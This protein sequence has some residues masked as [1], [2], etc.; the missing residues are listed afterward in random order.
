MATA[1]LIFKDSV[2]RQTVVDISPDVPCRIGRGASN[3]IVFQSDLISRNHAMVQEGDDGEYLLFDLGSRNGTVLNGRRV[4]I[5][6]KLQDGD[7]IG[8]GEFT[9][10]F[11]N[12][13][14]APEPSSSAPDCETQVVVSIRWIA[15]LVADIRGFTPLAL[16]L[17]ETRIAELMAAFN[18]RVGAVLDSAGA[19]THKFSGD[20]VMAI[21]IQGAEHAS[22]GAVHSAL[23]AVVPINAIV[24][25]L[26]DEFNL[27]APIGIGFG[28]NFGVASVGNV[29]SAGAADH[30]ALGD[31]VNRAFRLEAST[32]VI[33]GDLVFGEEV[34]TVLLTTIGAHMEPIGTPHRILLKGYVSEAEVYSISISQAEAITEILNRTGMRRDAAFIP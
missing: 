14:A 6:T 20:A 22:I 24:A 23:S 33:A 31:V 21:W 13:M 32:R 2:D 29:G 7:M 9:L 1:K 27:P 28:L 5:P 16:Q 19:W 10:A 12:L 11:S 34:R 8:I 17:G 26:K 25:A 4:T 30:T 3:T 18:R 15:V